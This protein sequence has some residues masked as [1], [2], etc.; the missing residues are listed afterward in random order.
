[1]EIS[2]DHK[3]VSRFSIERYLS[4]ELEGTMHEQVRVAIEQDD[5]IR[6]YVHA[7]TMD[8]N[9]FRAT[10]PVS[11]LQ[12]RLDEHLQKRSWW[13]WMVVP[14][15]ASMMI[16]ACAVLLLVPMMLRQSLD[17]QDTIRVRGGLQTAV[18]VKRGEQVLE[19]DANMILKEGDALQI[20]V[21]D[22]TGGFLVVMG[23]SEKGRVDV[24]RMPEMMKA[25]TGFVSGSLVLDASTEAE[26]LYVIMTENAP[27]LDVL[28]NQL[29]SAI[30][31]S[32]PPVLDV[33]NARVA[34][35]DLRKEK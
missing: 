19:Y 20:R 15:Y 11:S 9:A 27:D 25:G 6:A 21:D 13:A 22:P 32:F 8:Q 34:R 29:Q 4:G 30:R 10:Y 16:A 7:R 3:P 2:W 14:R 35:I 1:M 28:R 17:T 26:S 24:Y 33:D 23:A 31:V 5:Q 12:A 18:F